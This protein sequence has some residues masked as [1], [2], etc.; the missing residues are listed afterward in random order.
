MRGLKRRRRQQ[1]LPFAVNAENNFP[2]IIYVT[3]CQFIIVWINIV[4]DNR[5][6]LVKVAN[7]LV[8]NTHQSRLTS[9]VL[10]VSFEHNPT[11]TLTADEAHHCVSASWLATIE[12]F[13]QNQSLNNSGVMAIS[14]RHDEKALGKVFETVADD[15]EI[16]DTFL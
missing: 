3:I 8:L 10:E 6:S 13:R 4:L 14:D 5:T 15:I 1:A 16:L 9:M 12:H 2:S 7:A 11:S